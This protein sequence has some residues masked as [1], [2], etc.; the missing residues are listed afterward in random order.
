MDNKLKKL[1]YLRITVEVNVGYTTVRYRDV[2][3]QTY[4]KHIHNEN[5]KCMFT[6]PV[7]GVQGKKYK[8]YYQAMYDFIKV[9]QRDK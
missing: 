7:K 3:E 8:N 4:A 5:G 9:R 6:Y 1:L 2:D